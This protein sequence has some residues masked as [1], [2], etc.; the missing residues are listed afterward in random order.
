MGITNRRMYASVRDSN[1][2]SLSA[3]SF[4]LGKDYNT[5]AEIIREVCT[6]TRD[7]T[8]TDEDKAIVK[9]LDGVSSGVNPVYY[10]RGKA[11]DYSLGGN[12]SLNCPYGYCLNDDLSHNFTKIQGSGGMG[13]VYSENIDDNQFI[14]YMAFGIPVYNSLRGFYS[15]AVDTSLADVMLN[16]PSVIS[17]RKIGRLLGWAGGKLISLPILPLVWLGKLYSGLTK[18]PINKYYDFKNQ[19]P[20]YFRMVN[21]LLV[22]VATNLGFRDYQFKNHKYDATNMSQTGSK[23]NNATESQLL[24]AVE[25]VPDDVHSYPDFI[26]RYKLD[27]F[28]IMHRKAEFER[29]QISLGSIS[30]DI[31]LEAQTLESSTNDAKSK[32]ND[33][34]SNKTWMPSWINGFWNAYKDQIYNQALY[35]GFRVDK[36]VDASESLTN[37]IG[38]SEVKSTLNSKFAQLENATFAIFGGKISDGIIGG[39]VQG[40]AKGIGEVASSAFSTLTGVG[41]ASELAT[42]SARFDI[43]DIWQDSSF[44]KNYNFKLRFKTPYGNT[45]SILQDV[46]LPYLCLLAGACPRAT[47]TSSYTSPFLCQAYLKGVFSVSLGM[48]ESLSVSRGDDMHG[49]ASNGLPTSITVNFSIKDMSPAMYPSLG[50]DMGIFDTIVGNTTSMQDYLMTLSGMGLIDRTDINSFANLRRRFR[51]LLEVPLSAKFNP[52]YWGA[53][54]GSKSPVRMITNIIAGPQGA[55]R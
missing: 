33:D 50:D 18:V 44:S 32:D 30:T 25:T 12:D 51:L 49:W 27:I 5:T 11:R 19:M 52:Y 41:G 37:S 45:I 6:S 39:M 55:N 40:L 20:L 7:G 43:P 42:G 14:L 36:T 23:I 54:A 34:G 48:I 21:T 46:Y 9:G 3:F 31:G 28:R 15:N 29:A 4:R 8:I 53:L 16:G 13:R 10:S 35:I 38:P 47:G 17:F 24:N 26:S 22:S 1:I 2:T